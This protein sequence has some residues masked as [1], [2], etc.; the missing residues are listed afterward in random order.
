MGK[1]E[2]N[3]CMVE[4]A[5]G[6]DLLKHIGKRIRLIRQIRNMT[7]Q[8]MANELNVTRKQ[9]QNYEIG[10][11]NIGVTRLW[12]IASLL[13]VNLSFFIEGL[14]ENKEG[15]S[16]ENLQIIRYFNKISD[17]DVKKNMMDLLKSL[18]Y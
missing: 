17:K 11:T 4:I 2:K 9:I 5:S 12:Q 1:T 14:D 7:M 6:A 18:N 15:I 3:D 16:E 8:K 10:L 13:N